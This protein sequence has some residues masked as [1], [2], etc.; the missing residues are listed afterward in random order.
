MNFLD[1]RLKVRNFF[2]KYKK[3]LIII[4]I[5]WAII[6]AIN[7]FLKQLNENQ[8]PTTTY[9]PNKAV[10]DD[11][12]VPKALQEPI[13]NLIGEFV[14]YCND[15]NYETAYS[16][17][18]ADCK[19]IS[20]PTI[21]SFKAYVDNI[22]TTKK[23]Y[24]IQNFSNVD[25]NYIYNVRILD[26]IMATGTNGNGYL[27][28]E[29]KFVLK[30]TDQGLKLSIGGFIEKKDLNISTED[31]YLKIEIPYKI[32]EYDTETYVVKVTNRTQNPIVLLDD[33]I[34]NEIELSLGN[35]RRNMQNSSENLIMVNAR[36][37]KTV[38]LYFTKFVDDGNIPEKLMFNAV[39]VLQSYAGNEQNTVDNAIDKYSLN[40][41]L[42][43]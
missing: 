8:K 25:N 32:V 39:R 13:N 9:E 33:S 17:I 4:I 3:L 2:K 20:Y 35:Q 21:D 37:T 43:E 14:G 16:M 40:I 42:P 23:I 1:L 38:K 5:V 10:M 27:Y 31:E 26:D 34:S 30:D 12:E 11:S 41:D 15:K 36:E 29:E 22:Y 7:Y 28:Y 19:E 6:I 18:D 24:N